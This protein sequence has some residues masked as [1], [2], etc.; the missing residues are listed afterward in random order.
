MASTIQSKSLSP[1]AQ[2]IVAAVR[3]N[4]RGYPSYVAYSE[5]VIDQTLVR[6]YKDGTITKR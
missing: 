6:I 1:Q 3:R 4:M 2:K 5:L